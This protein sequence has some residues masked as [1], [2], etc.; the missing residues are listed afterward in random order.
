MPVPTYVV[1]LSFGSSGYIDVSSYA[2]SVTMNRGISRS[3]EDYS[4][5][6]VS[7]TFVNNARVFDPLNT[8]SIL[9]YS[10]GGYTIVQPGGKIRVSAN[11]IRVF[12]GFVQDWDFTYDSAGLD[13]RATVTAL[14]EIYRVGNAFFTGGTATVIEGTSDR[15][16]RVMNNN[17]FGA[18]EYA[19]VNGSQTIVG[20]DVNEAGDSVLAY[21][22]QLART[23]P[24]D[25]YSNASAVMVMKDRSFTNYV[26]TNS[27]RQNL[28]KYPG[29]ATVAVNGSN[30]WVYGYQA[31]STV[32]TPYGGTANKS[33]ISIPD[34]QDLMSYQE[35]DYNKYN[36]DGGSTAYVF[37]GFF[38]G[39]TG[40]VAIEVD[41][42]L[43]DTLGTIAG[44]AISTV[45]TSSTAWTQLSA[46]A[47]MTGGNGTAGGVL[48]TVFANGTTS[49]SDFFGNGIQVERGTAWINYFDGTYNPYTNDASNVYFN[50][51]GGTAYQSSSGMLISSASAISAPTI[52]TFA[53][54]NSQGASYGNGTG[55]AFSEL[56][57]M[58]GA[59]NLYN[60]VQVAAPNA[61]AIAEDSSG[62]TKY[63]LKTFSQTDNLT[64]STTKPAQIA[65]S[66][67]AEYRLPEYRANE[68]TLQLESLTSAQQN[69]I[70]AIELRDVI[71]VCFQ[72]SATGSVVDKYYQ[73]LSMNSN[74]N[75]ESHTLTF[76]LASLDNLP[77]RLD[78][79]LLAVLDT[80]TLG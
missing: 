34:L 70:L 3:L 68:I 51:W 20:L 55:I 15:I 38:K 13:G 32:V 35:V 46:T 40:A 47:T 78:S 11:G 65:S 48:F 27:N 9:W 67:L 74:M 58:Y 71:R 28:V 25:F 14:D 18:A 19:G 7:I 77:I 2:Q 57:V 60:K 16:K 45:T 66:L 31:A 22:Q 42:Y 49:S 79:T 30:G 5:G 75:P 8:S 54:Q 36:P 80:D 52:L 12:T 23:E 33:Q 62:Q 73:V 39:S 56:N 6:S 37:S 69:L 59:E 41:F 1:E 63:G 29:T 4:A 50:A 53:D 10:A 21:L 26:W 64:I 17:S 72:P 43:L 24:A 44:T 61:T 76:T